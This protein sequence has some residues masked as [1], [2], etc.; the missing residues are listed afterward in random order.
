MAIHIKAALWPTAKSGML[1]QWS[2]ISPTSAYGAANF[3]LNFERFDLK[4]SWRQLQASRLPEGEAPGQP[5]PSLSSRL[6]K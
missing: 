1:K 3:F 2:R 6:C 4:G 5:R